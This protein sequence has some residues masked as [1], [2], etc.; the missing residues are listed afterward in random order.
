[1]IVTSDL[2]KGTVFM[3]EGKPLRVLEYAHIKMSRG[4]AVIKLKVQELLSGA[5]K[6]VSLPNGGRVEEADVTNKNMQFLYND[7]E[8]LNFMDN[9]D[10]SQVQL[11]VSAAE[12]E[13]KFLVEGK[14]FQVTF[15]DQNPIAI[16]LPVGMYFKVTEADPAVKGNTS[17]NALKEI[18]LENGLKLQAPMFIKPGDVVKINTTT[19]EYVERGQQNRE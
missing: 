5:I 13:A 6:D 19:G 18:T 11:P 8:Y 4:G 1:M 9:T 3:H 17:N 7:G 12:Y 15:Y 16:V 2:R 10:Y 14:D